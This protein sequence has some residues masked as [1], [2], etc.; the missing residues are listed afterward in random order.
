MP[1]ITEE[2]ME[3][4]EFIAANLISPRKFIQFNDILRYG[5]MYNK[6]IRK[7]PQLLQ[8]MVDEQLSRGQQQFYKS[9]RLVKKSCKIN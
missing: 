1:E 8:R 4:A 7:D 5:R 3:S 2:A 6:E 9:K